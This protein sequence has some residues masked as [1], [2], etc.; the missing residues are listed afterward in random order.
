MYGNKQIAQFR[1]NLQKVKDNND[2]IILMSN[3]SNIDTTSVIYLDYVG[4]RWCKGHTTIYVGAGDETVDIP[5]TI[6]YADIITTGTSVG[7]QVV[8]PPYIEEEQPK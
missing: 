5:E 8:F 1:A 7:L 4:E 3:Y 2:Y 6:N